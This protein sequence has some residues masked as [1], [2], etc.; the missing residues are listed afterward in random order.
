VAPRVAIKANFSWTR[1]YH[2]DQPI[3]KAVN[4]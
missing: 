4:A 3:Y 1:P 2:P